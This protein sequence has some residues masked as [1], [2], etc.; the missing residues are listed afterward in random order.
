MGEDE[1][2]VP[3]LYLFVHFH[4]YFSVTCVLRSHLSEALSSTRKAIDA[5]LSAYVLI[6]DPDKTTSYLERDKYFR[7]IK[8]NIQRRLEKD[9]SSFPLAR[10]LLNI[11]GACSEF[12]SHADVSSFFHRLQI[13]DLDEKNSEILF[14]Y[15]QFPSNLDGYSFYFLVILQAFF[16]VFRI[17][18]L[19]F[20]KQLEIV[21]PVWE[22]RIAELG[23]TLENLR[24]CSPM[25]MSP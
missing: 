9:E 3:Q 14:H 10:E 25:I 4:L 20:D 11:H 7:A 5:A 19:F 15:F 1:A 22:G 24:C 12:G 13:T 23:P 16:L 17:F 21:D 8:A 18:K 6:L 2:V